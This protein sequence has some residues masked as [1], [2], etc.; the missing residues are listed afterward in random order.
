MNNKASLQLGGDNWAAKD[1]NLLAYKTSLSEKNFLPIEFD[2]ERGAN[3]AATRV[4]ENGLIEK[5]REN[6]LLQSNQFDTTWATSAAASVVGGQTGYDG[7]SDAW[8]LSKTGANQYIQQQITFGG[9]NTLSAY[10]KAGTSTWVALMRGDGQKAFFDLSGNGAL[11]NV[12]NGIT[13][14]IES[15]GSGWFRCSFTFE[16]SSTNYARIYPADGD[17]DTSG[18]SGNLYIQDAQ[19]E[20]GLAATD[21]IET[22]ATTAQAG[23]LEELPRINYSGSTPSLL[24]EP[25]RTNSWIHSEYLDYSFSSV[26]DV[27]RTQNTTETLSPEGLYNATKLEGI[28]PWGMR[29]FI[30][31]TNTGTWTISCYVKAVNPSSNNTFRLSVGG[32]NHSSNFTATEEW[33]RFEHTFTNGGAT[34]TGILRDTSTNDADLYIYGFQV[35]EGSYPTSY[36]PTYGTAATRG[37]DTITSPTVFNGGS[38]FSLYFEMGPIDGNDQILLL[39]T[40][41]LDFYFRW[42]SSTTLNIWNQ[43]NNSVLKQ[44]NGLN[45]N[46]NNKI[47]MVYDGSGGNL[48][49]VNGTKYTAADY[50]WPSLDYIISIGSQLGIFGYPAANSKTFKSILVFPE[51]LS[52][53]ECITLTTL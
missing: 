34:A 25:E 33:Q 22:G 13:S 50:T 28:G 43:D 3:L 40:S 12:L 53:A 23:V 26:T 39:Q 4:D 35:E 8:L 18:T 6:L 49:F 52:D 15:I 24:L 10:I 11:G 9:I 31:G 20:V 36:I 47:L 17:G 37:V 48:I 1:T 46:Q 51:A 38:A 16:N 29:E 21:Y 5:G 42:T 41:P 44:I 2:F 19:L 7:S 30:T 45:R 14:K 32:N 27:T